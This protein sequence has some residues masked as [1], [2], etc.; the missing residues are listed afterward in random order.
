MINKYFEELKTLAAV[1][2]SGSKKRF[3]TKNK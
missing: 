2:V 1:K 3:S